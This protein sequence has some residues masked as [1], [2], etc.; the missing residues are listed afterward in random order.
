MP[1]TTRPG[2]TRPPRPRSR[3]VGSPVALSHGGHVY[4]LR[5]VFGL[6]CESPYLRVNANTFLYRE[7]SQRPHHCICSYPY[8][9]WGSR[10]PVLGAPAVFPATYWPSHITQIIFSPRLPNS[11]ILVYPI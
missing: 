4:P 1:W 5:S 7:I 6:L 10:L 9:A 8:G 2:S 3:P 11:W